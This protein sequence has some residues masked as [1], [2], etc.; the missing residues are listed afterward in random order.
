MPFLNKSKQTVYKVK[1]Q[2]VEKPSD[3][4]IIRFAENAAVD[5]IDEGFSTV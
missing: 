1:N 5:D 2:T 4:R 3:T